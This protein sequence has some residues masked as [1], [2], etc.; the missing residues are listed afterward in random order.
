LVIA[1]L[2]LALLFV[3]GWLILP[4]LS[5][6]RE[7]RDARDVFCLQPSEQGALADAAMALDVAD[8][9][10]SVTGI[11]IG[12]S[13]V[14]LLDWRD[15]HRD[16][17]NRTCDALSAVRG[18]PATQSGGVDSVVLSIL[19][20]VLTAALSYAVNRSQQKAT[21]GQTDASELR[22]A[23]TA[24]SDAANQ[25]LDSRVTFPAD[26]PSTE[27]DAAR[28]ELVGRLGGVVEREPAWVAVRDVVAL[29]RTGDLS[30]SLD[31]NLRAIRDNTNRG[32]RIGEMRKRIQTVS[33][34]GFLVADALAENGGFDKRL[35][36]PLPEG[37]RA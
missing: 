4:K 28:D 16:D 23:V 22:T 19:G 9:G 27:M 25:F 30:T 8:K 14:S 11:V 37:V 6:S 29:L 2:A 10:S 12:N 24:Y 32:R 20:I 36:Q 17:F 31:Q 34:I 7:T 15:D 21:R 5:V 1:A 3:V 35:T 13:S 33:D 18:K 26:L